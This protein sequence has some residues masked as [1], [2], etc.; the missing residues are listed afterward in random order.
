[1]HVALF[2]VLDDFIF[3]NE[4]ILFSTFPMNNFCWYSMS[5]Y[6]IPQVFVEIFEENLVHVH[7]LQLAFP[8]Y[9]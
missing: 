8:T 5:K 1:M 3:I 7:H 4:W 2:K 9:I 6:S